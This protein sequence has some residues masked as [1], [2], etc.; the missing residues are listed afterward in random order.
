MAGFVPA[1]VHPRGR[2]AQNSLDLHLRMP[3]AQR[4]ERRDSRN[5]A[6]GRDEPGH[7]G[8][9]QGMV[10]RNLLIPALMGRRP[11][12][13]QGRPFD[14]LLEDGESRMIV[15]GVRAGADLLIA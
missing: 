9:L 15:A 10:S 12:P 13:H 11:R 3:S 6:D 7:D 4:I 1:I 14:P 8:P 5:G 2:L